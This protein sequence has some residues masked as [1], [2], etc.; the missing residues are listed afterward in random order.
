MNAY[1]LWIWIAIAAVVILV[2]VGLIAVGARRS[3]S[4]ALR[5]RFGTEYDVAVR[6]AGNRTAGEEDL[7][8]RAEEV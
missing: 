2:I 5:Q 1:P 8:R 3:R 7:A 4:A 6:R